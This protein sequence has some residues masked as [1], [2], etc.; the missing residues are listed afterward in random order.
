M[1]FEVIEDVE[2]RS[3]EWF[4]QRLGR[5]T[6]SIAADIMPSDKAR[7]EWTQG[8]LSVL[9]KLAAERLTG[10][11]EES[12]TSK[13]M[14]WGIDHEDEALGAL[15]LHLDTVIGSSPFYPI[16]DYAG[17]SPDGENWRAVY[18]VKCPSSKQHFKY[19]LNPESLFDDYKWQV[20][21]EV[22]ATGLPFAYIA[23]Y[24]PRF[25]E[26]KRLV[27]FEPELI[28]DE[29]EK[30]KARVKAADEKIKSWIK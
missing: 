6:G 20:Y 22:W 28:E 3:E 23:S 29:M 27:V 1:N 16:D 18:E 12:Y 19:M 11:R 9:Q 14:Q 10:Q 5:I 13:A 25:P 4:K 26:G 7:V 24:D 17:A 21:M 30:L 15:E 2:Q 8:Q